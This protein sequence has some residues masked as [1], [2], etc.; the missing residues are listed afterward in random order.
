MSKLRIRWFGRLRLVHRILAVNLLTIVL[1]ACGVLYLDAFRNQL[2]E[3]RTNLIR[4]EAKISASVLARTPAQSRPAMLEALARWLAPTRQLG[5]D[6][7]ELQV[8]RSC[9]TEMAERCRESGGPRLQRIGRSQAA[10]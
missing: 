3:E 9:R 6:R 2:S 8:T 7:P 5:S 10:G 1:L 4:R